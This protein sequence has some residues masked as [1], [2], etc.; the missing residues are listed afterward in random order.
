M[1]AALLFALLAASPSGPDDP[2]IATVGAAEIRRS[3]V[4]RH[5]G[6]ASETG[7]A[8][9]IAEAC[10]ESALAHQARSQLGAEVA[11]LDDAAAARA[12]LDRTFSPERSCAAIPERER[13]AYYDANRWRFV[14]PPAWVVDD[15]QLLCCT[16]PRACQA[17][18][19][20][21][22]LA[23]AAPDAQRLRERIP[24]TVDERAFAAAFDAAVADEPRLGFKRY[25]FYFDPARPDARLD[26]HLQEVDRP[27][28]VAVAA[29]PSPGTV[30]PV[31]E[32]RFGHH[33]LRLAATRPALDLGF[34]DP[35]AQAL[36]VTELC[37]ARLAEERDR[38]VH[39]LI[40]PMGV[41]VRPD[42]YA[43]VTRGLSEVTRP[44]RPAPP[45]SPS[46]PRG[47]GSPR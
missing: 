12:L 10:R 32:T 11:G 47:P 2:L 6:E 45:G 18:D 5:L 31:V 46:G 19:V 39:D 27:V 35:R 23:D 16:S 9:A 4:L 30:T 24:D 40:G 33:V 34:D 3:D 42:A 13:R 43:V 26:P 17:P 22:C 38:F 36:V 37:P 1:V 25:T 20:A 29:L 21:A 8:A 15:L 14:S 44:A 41:G 7:V 28:A